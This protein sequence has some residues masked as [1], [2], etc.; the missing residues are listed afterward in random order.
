MEAPILCTFIIYQPLESTGWISLSTWFSPWNIPGIPFLSFTT[1]FSHDQPSHCFENWFF[2]TFLPAGLTILDPLYFHYQLL[3]STG[4]TT[5]SH[6]INNV[7][8]ITCTIWLCQKMGIY[9][10]WWSSNDCNGYTIFRQ[11]L[12]ISWSPCIFHDRPYK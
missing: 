3:W 12:G 5:F 11:T 1:G 4:P 6:W 7:L 8:T 2:T 9:P 10:K